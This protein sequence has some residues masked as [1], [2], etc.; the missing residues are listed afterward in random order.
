MAWAIVSNIP[1][2]RPFEARRHPCCTPA[3]ICSQGP[4]DGRA[5]DAHPSRKP[6]ACPSQQCPFQGVTLQVGEVTF[7]RVHRLQELS[8]VDAGFRS[9]HGVF[10]PYSLAL[11]ES[12]QKW[13]H[14][15]QLLSTSCLDPRLRPPVTRKAMTNAY[16]REQGPFSLR[17]RGGFACQGFTMQQTTHEYSS[18]SRVS[19]RRDW[20]SRHRDSA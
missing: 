14:T 17:C 18:L 5:A 16:V 9:R 4:H 19:A 7:R 12:W 10:G 15:I 1:R 11:T 13:F 8:Q 6:L 2:T 3:L 20:E